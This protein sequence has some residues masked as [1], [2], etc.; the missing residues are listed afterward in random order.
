MKKTFPTYFTLKTPDTLFLGSNLASAGRDEQILRIFPGT[1]VVEAWRWA[2]GNIHKKKCSLPS[3]GSTVCKY[4]APN[5]NERKHQLSL[6]SRELVWT[7]QK[8]Q[9]PE[10]AS[11]HCAVPCSIL[12]ATPYSNTRI[13]KSHRSLFRVPHQLA[14]Y[15]WYK[16]LQR[17]PTDSRSQAQQDYTTHPESL[18]GS[19]VSYAWQG[20]TRSCVS[21]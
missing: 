12:E 4:L 6:L 7:R 13:L 9:Q 1:I 21:S 14:G 8:L 5:S 17:N 20:A 11:S 18:S 2:V 15:D 19:R 3:Q 16:P 10:G